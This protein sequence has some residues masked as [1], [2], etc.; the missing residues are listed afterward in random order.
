MV[1][2]YKKTLTYHWSKHSTS[3]NSEIHKVIAALICHNGRSC[4]AA[5]LSTGTYHNDT[6]KC[7]TTSTCD[8]HAVSICYEA[9]PKYFLKEIKSLKNG[10]DSI[11]ECIPN[12]EGFRL[13]PEISFHL[14]VTQFP[15]GF[16]QDQKEPCMEWKTPFIEYPHVPTC[17][18]RILI[19]ATM[20][21]QG[22][23]S[24]LLDKPI[25]I[26][27]LVILSP[28]LDDYPVLDFG[29]S[30]K[31]PKVIKTM[32]YDP[33][34]FKPGFFLPSEPSVYKYSLKYEHCQSYTS[35]ESI[36]G[37]ETAKSVGSSLERARDSSVIVATPD[38]SERI[39]F[40]K[41]DP[42]STKEVTSHFD[43]SI[44][45]RDID[46]IFEVDAGLRIQRISNL[47]QIYDDL[48]I[49]L[50]LEEALE[51]LRCKLDAESKNNEGAMS[52]L[53]QSLSEE[54]ITVPDTLDTKSEKE[55][56]SYIQKQFEMKVRN[57]QEKGRI[58]IR[59][60]HMVACIQKILTKKGEHIMM[61]CNWY[62]YLNS[63]PS[64]FQPTSDE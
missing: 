64:S 12:K 33:E 15:C 36:D 27:S 1:D 19:G 61:D 63:I 58:K 42:R 14:F 11:F 29:N 31:M 40:L 28:N 24:H 22:Y 59:N 48:A 4:Y 32:R 37:N 26:D 18:T 13:K 52:T 5:I 51:M 9:A 49:R 10:D 62:Q 21:I 44:K 56:D 38:R 43:L 16:I 25:M 8:G 57:M 2:C 41:F 46:Q 34:D 35:T 54:L 6:E 47:K 23:I 20:G 60:Q 30:F 50:K 53:I 55:W 17:S 45:I 7:G 3:D 39:G